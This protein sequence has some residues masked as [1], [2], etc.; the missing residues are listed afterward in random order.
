M[1]NGW[2]TSEMKIQLFFNDIIMNSMNIHFYIHFVL[3][4][5]SKKV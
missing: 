5:Q 1:N 2:G 3:A 4:K